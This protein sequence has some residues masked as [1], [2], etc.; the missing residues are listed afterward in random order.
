MWTSCIVWLEDAGGFMLPIL[1]KQV[2]FSTILFAIVLALTTLLRKQ[3]PLLH[4]GLWMLVLIRLVLPTDLSFPISARILLGHLTGSLRKPV[5]S[6]VVTMTSDQG[7]SGELSLS[8][9]IDDSSVISAG[10]VWT[11]VSAERFIPWKSVLFAGW[12]TGVFILLAVYLKKLQDYHRMVRKAKN[13]VIKERLESLE[14]WK[15]LYRIRRRVRLVTSDEYL[16]PFTI[17]ILRPVVYLPGAI[18]ETENGTLAEAVISHE[19]AH[20]RCFDALWMKLQN[21]VQI[22]YFFH[23]VAWITGSRIHLLR[24]CICDSLV[25]SK[26]KLSTETY[27]LGL[28]SVLKW[29]VF[30]TD[31]VSIL[32]GFGSPRKKVLQRIQNIKNTKSAGK[33]TILLI[34]VTVTIL[35][36]FILPMNGQDKKSEDQAMTNQTDIIPGSD[37][38]SDYKRKANEFIAIIDTMKSKVNYTT[39]QYEFLVPKDQDVLSFDSGTVE[40][41]FIDTRDNGNSV[42]VDY[43]GY[44]ISYGNLKGILVTESQRIKQWQPIGRLNQAEHSD[45]SK[46]ILSY[47]IDNENSTAGLVIPE[48]SNFNS[49]SKVTPKAFD[50]KKCANGIVAMVDLISKFADDAGGKFELIMPQGQEISSFKDGWIQEI[51]ND[52]NLVNFPYVV[53]VQYPKYK[54]SYEGL[55]K[56]YV[57]KGETV[58]QWQAIGRLGKRQ[59]NSPDSSKLV[60]LYKFD[61]IRKT[62]QGP[63]GT[64]SANSWTDDK[65]VFSNPV[66]NGVVTSLFGLRVDPILGSLGVHNGVD[67]RCPKGTPVFAT[68]DGT[69]LIAENRY[70]KGKGEGRHILIDHSNGFQTRYTQLD[71]VLVRK[72]QNVNRWEMI[73]KIGNTGRSTGPHLHYE[74]IKDG[75]PVNPENWIRFHENVEEQSPKNMS[76]DKAT[77]D[78]FIHQ[79]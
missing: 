12:M 24:E 58:K 43:D 11:G 40:K 48:P 68:A 26:R 55:D 73:G 44:W 14:H 61:K 32:P 62:T 41:I 71:T 31:E 35:A 9:P 70:V 56:V 36:L 76:I 13:V 64:E 59:T 63:S 60:M 54:L 2:V 30:G 7:L 23:P 20:V 6:S 3:S 4:L 28:L 53:W 45:R 37:A 69:V 5:A 17:G 66:P 21:L 25:I 77:T 15:S 29:N 19:L 47:K 79:L 10:S 39:A 75:I 74:V 18:A 33:M 50:Y 57:R 46:L 51:I 8:D 1:Q 38:I 22:A 72:G 67:I 78:E 49:S 42:R 27:G 65:N 16:S 34:A 52:S